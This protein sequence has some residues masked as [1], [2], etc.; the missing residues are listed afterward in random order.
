MLYHTGSYTLLTHLLCAWYTK[1]MRK[2]LTISLSLEDWQKVRHSART[3][4]E[5]YSSIFHRLIQWSFPTAPDRKRLEKYKALHAPV[6]A[7]LEE[8]ARVFAKAAFAKP[9]GSPTPPS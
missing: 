2:N 9:R 8:R 3:L 6:A 5:T 1:D 4:G 7:F